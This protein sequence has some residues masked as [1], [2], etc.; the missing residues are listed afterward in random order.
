MPSSRPNF[1][2]VTLQ[3]D[4]FC[5]MPARRRQCAAYGLGSRPIFSSRS[6]RFNRLPRPLL[7]SRAS[8]TEIS[9]DSAV[10]DLYR[11]RNQ[12]PGH[13][14]IGTS[15]TLAKLL[16]TLGGRGTPSALPREVA[17]PGREGCGFSPRRARRGGFCN[18]QSACAFSR[19]KSRVSVHN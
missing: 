12:S 7:R 15:R 1:A 18:Y 14:P 16:L 6:R 13:G 9:A 17:A 8:A 4:E 5:L 11:D 3:C 2:G 10:A 19:S